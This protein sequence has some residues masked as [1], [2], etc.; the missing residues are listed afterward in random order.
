MIFGDA[1]AK[2]WLRVLLEGSVPHGHA[3]PIKTADVG[4]GCSEKNHE[5][6]GKT[7]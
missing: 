5:K 6:A 7:R 4:D 2:V 1:I 3:R